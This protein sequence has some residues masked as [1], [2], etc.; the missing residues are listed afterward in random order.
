[1]RV[2]NLLWLSLFGLSAQLPAEAADEAWQQQLEAA[3][4]QTVYFHAW[5]GSAEANRYLRWAASELRDDYGIR[6]RHVRV[7]DIS[8]A[9]TRILAESRDSSASSAIDLLWVNG[10]NFHALK[11]A[12]ALLGDLSSRVPNSELINPELPYEMD[13]GVAVDDFELPWGMGQF[14]LFYD[15]NNSPELSGDGY[16]TPAS[17]LEFARANP[18]QISYPLPPDFHGTTFL[19]QLLI[20]LTDEDS[21]LQEPFDAE[22]GEPLL[23]TLFSYLDELHPLLWRE[24]ESFMSS[25]AEQQRRFADGRLKLALSFNPGELE[26]ARNKGSLPASTRAASLGPKAITNS[27]YLA[28]PRNA[29]ARPAALVVINF[30]L[31]PEAQQRKVDSEHWGDPPVLKPRHLEQAPTLQF[32]PASEPHVSWNRAIEQAWRERYE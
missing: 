26:A 7:A 14:H 5:G 8:E 15:T 29:Q 23:N 3:R 28:V 21:R 1:M 18:G 10:K 13:F 32:T 16:L 12:E 25:A 2:L 6:L 31:S 20:A 22:S 24:G 19:K 9:V 4:G 11:S 17:L 27:H 30:L